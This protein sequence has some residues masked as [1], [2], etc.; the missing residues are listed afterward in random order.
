MSAPMMNK[1]QLC[2]AGSACVESTGPSAPAG[3]PSRYQAAFRAASANKAAAVVLAAVALAVGAAA[4]LVVSRDAPLQVIELSRVVITAQRLPPGSCPVPIEPAGA[5]CPVP[6][7]AAP[8]D[9]AVEPAVA[10]SQP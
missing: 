7:Q 3:T 8:A 9:A 10:R 1:L 2:G 5:E 6:L 4:W